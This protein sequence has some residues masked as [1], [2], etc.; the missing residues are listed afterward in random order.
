MVLH[1]QSEDAEVMLNDF[2]TI[3]VVLL[4]NSFCYHG[5][6]LLM[7]LSLIFFQKLGFGVGLLT[8]TFHNKMTLKM[9]SG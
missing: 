7:S 4:T 8:K 5:V 1:L 6:P 3:N 2:V 9:V